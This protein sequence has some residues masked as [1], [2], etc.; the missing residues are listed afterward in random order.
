LNENNIPTAVHYPIPLHLQECFTDLNYKKNDFPI[1]K[2]A[3]KEMI[4]LPMSPFLTQKEQ[5][6]VIENIKIVC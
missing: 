5:D 2:L 3:S 4:S 1:S 6:F